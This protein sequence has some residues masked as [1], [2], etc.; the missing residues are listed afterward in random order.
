MITVKSM[1]QIATCRTI[2]SFRASSTLS[3]LSWVALDR[4]RIQ[5]AQ[6]AQRSHEH[7]RQWRIHQWIDR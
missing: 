5:A 7:H 6:G 4:G 2:P 3:R 1:R